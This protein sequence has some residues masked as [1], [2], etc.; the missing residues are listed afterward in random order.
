MATM[1]ACIDGGYLAANQNRALRA[2]K[3]SL[4][5]PGLALQANQNS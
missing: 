3:T 5:Y 1:D 2:L 4:A